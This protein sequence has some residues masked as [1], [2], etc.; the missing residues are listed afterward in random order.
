MTFDIAVFD[1]RTSALLST[2]TAEF[3]AIPE[4]GDAL[5]VAQLGD[6]RVQKRQADWQARLVSLHVVPEAEWGPL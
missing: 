5:F 4:W 6:C 3:G 1:H 2:D